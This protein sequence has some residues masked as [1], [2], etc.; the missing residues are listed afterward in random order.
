MYLHTDTYFMTLYS[1][2][3]HETLLFVLTDADHSNRF[4]TIRA[5]GVGWICCGWVWVLLGLVRQSSFLSGRGS[6]CGLS[7]YSGQE[8]AKQRQYRLGKGCWSL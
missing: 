7:V 4:V 6:N 8:R 5:R 2:K 1:G 3:N